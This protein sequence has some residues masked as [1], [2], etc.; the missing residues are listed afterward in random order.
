MEIVRLTGEAGQFKVAQ[1]YLSSQRPV[2]LVAMVSKNLV[3]GIGEVE[4]KRLNSMAGQRAMQAACAFSKPFGKGPPLRHRA[5]AKLRRHFF[6]RKIDD[7]R[8]RTKHM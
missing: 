6:R 2:Y 5:R 3:A 8:L 1:P 7:D 4:K